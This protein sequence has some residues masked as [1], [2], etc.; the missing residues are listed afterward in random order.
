MAVGPALAALNA[1]VIDCRRCPRLVAY[2]EAVANARK[3]Q[4][5][6][7]VYW[8]RPVAG[9][10]DPRARIFLVGLAPAAHGGNRTGRIFTGDGSGD[11][12][13][14]ALYRVGLASQPT[15]THRDDGLRLRRTY[16][17]SAAR[18]APPDNKPLPSEFDACREYLM[19]EFRLL[20]G[21]RAI[22]A[23]GQLAHTAAL[24]TAAALGWTIPTPRPAFAHG[25]RSTITPPEREP[26]ALLGSYHPSRQNTN[27]G[28]LTPAMLERVL[29]QA[30]QV[31]G[32]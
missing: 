26:I 21:L 20:V 27:T 2:R 29:R 10:G 23:L 24:K 30:V 28:R 25:A 19:E 4:F 6:D 3:R 9:F 12:L 18:C 31:A 22:V 8:G 1:R 15:S 16:M 7:F 11:F 17:A 32:V 14:R 5:A 13:T